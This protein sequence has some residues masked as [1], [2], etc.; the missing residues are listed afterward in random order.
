MVALSETDIT[1]SGMETEKK[2]E[3]K[4]GG[5][6]SEADRDAR[7]P[8]GKEDASTLPETG[9]W[10]AL[11]DRFAIQGRLAGYANKSAFLDFL[12]SARSGQSERSVTPAKGWWW[13]ILVVL[14]GGVMLN[15]TPCVLPIIPINIAIIGA[16]ARAGSRVR[17]FMLGGA[18]GLGI[19]AVY[20][21]LGLEVELGLSAAFGALNST[22]WFNGAIAILFIVLALAMLDIIQ[23]DFSK[24]QAKLGLGGGGGHILAALGM[25]AVSALLAGAC[26]APVVIYTILQAQDLYSQGHAIA[27]ALPFGLGVGM[28]L[29]WPFLGAGLSL[30]PK[31]GVWMTRVKQGFA[32]FILGFALYYGHLAYTLYAPEQEMK[33][34]EGPW[35]AS[36]ERGLA[37]AIEQQRPVIIDFWATWCK[38]CT[39]MDKTVL[40][41]EEVLSKLD[42]YVKI[43][44][45]A[46]SLTEPPVADV[47]DYFKVLG[48]PTFIV[49]EPK[50]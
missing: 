18:Y 5:R 29:P 23:I 43:K 33:G 12:D 2:E 42:G 35:T 49:L 36:L 1:A 9:E 25:G 37:Q 19:A 47:I 26:V 34:L 3:K 17:G 4:A 13:M 24:F 50:G 22:A 16:G 44:F 11:A 8:E 28:A 46:E 40:R 21:A 20:G 32:V 14:G 41:D 10:R 45:Q 7:I 15:L 6:L 27:L 30:L 38:N 31:P 48:L 39:V